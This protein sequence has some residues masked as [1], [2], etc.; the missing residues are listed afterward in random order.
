MSRLAVQMNHVVKRF[1][2]VVANDRV[3]FSVARGEIH[4]LLGEN[5]AGK[6]TVMS[7]LS[8]IYRA[9]SGELFVHGERVRIRSPRDAMQLGIGMV[10]QNFRLVATLTA[11]DNI[12]LGE[13][14]Q[15][16]RGASWKR[17]KAKEISELCE[18][19][20]L[21]FPI[22]APVWQLSVGEQQRVEIVKTL[23]RGADIILL[24][25]PT[26]VLTP[27]E[28][29]RLF[30][31]LRE[32]KQS[33]KT[34]VITTHKL[35]EVMAAADR[36]SVMRK[37][38]MIASLDRKDTNAKELAELMVGRALNDAGEVPAGQ[39]GAAIMA[40]QEMTVLADH[41]YRALNGISFEVKEGEII[42]VAGVAGN[43]QK[44]LA[45]AIAGLRSWASGTMTCLGERME[46][47]SIRR[48]I[49]KGISLIPEDRMKSGL[50][51]SLGLVDNLMLKSYRGNER[52]RMGVLRNKDNERWAAQLI[53]R[54]DVRTP[55][56]TVPVRGLS[57]GNQQKLLL[58]REIDQKPKLMV[59]VHP[60]QGLD[61]GATES[62]HQMLLDLR[63]SSAGVLLIS[64]DLDEVMRLSDRI[65]VLYGGNIVGELSKTEIDKDRIG[66]MMAGIGDS[67][68]AAR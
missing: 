50:A 19:Y 39:A 3:D 62:V 30:M 57:G 12:I 32:L 47:A 64:E 33:G 5:G 16:W 20:G 59:A 23:Y 10:H 66:R 28:A 52:F 7:L 67:E 58:A 4:A 26:S 49:D 55:S 35:K 13:K 60:T 27:S 11:L 65:L 61:V 31:T 9:D 38:R 40:V 68:E 41:G 14:K 48:R 54:F 45:E 1:G 8:G 53:D 22:D 6:S 43:G 34:I 25:E 36:I 42:G 15:P 51:G 2:D 18:Q 63:D 17:K 44:E 56:L 46:G 29:E 21:Q 24:D 37:G